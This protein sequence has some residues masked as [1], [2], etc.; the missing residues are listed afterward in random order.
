MPWKLLDETIRLYEHLGLPDEFLKSRYLKGVNIWDDE[1]GTTLQTA[2][3]PS[4]ELGKPVRTALVW[5]KFGEMY[6]HR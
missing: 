4:Q 2:L 1:L 6:V 5:D 3:K